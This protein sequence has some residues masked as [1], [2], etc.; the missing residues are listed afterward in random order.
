MLCYC[1]S[2]ISEADMRLSSNS[3]ALQPFWD[4]FDSLTLQKNSPLRHLATTDS[5]LR[6]SGQLITGYCII[7]K[8]M[9]SPVKLSN[10]Q[11][12]YLGALAERAPGITLEKLAWAMTILWKSPITCNQICFLIRRI[13]EGKGTGDGYYDTWIWD[14]QP[15]QGH[16]EA[17]FEIYRKLY[18]LAILRDNMDGSLQPLWQQFDQRNQGRE[19]LKIFNS[20]VHRLP[21]AQQIMLSDMNNAQL[22]SGVKHIESWTEEVP[23]GSPGDSSLEKGGK[24]EGSASGKG[25]GKKKDDDDAGGKGQA[26]GKGKGKGKGRGKA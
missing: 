24:G 6:G 2:V 4:L 19:Q 20:D 17:H 10:T 11:V 25:K 21:V 22:K 23:P 9:A 16:M 3:I 5:V 13:R 18:D 26:K 12:S 1:P 14:G 7:L 8:E 15:L